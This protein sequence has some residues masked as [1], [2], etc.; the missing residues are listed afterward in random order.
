VTPAKAAAD[1]ILAVRLAI[2]PG[3]FLK[4]AKPADLPVF[5][6]SLFELIINLRPTFFGVGRSPLM[7]ASDRATDHD[8]LP[9]AARALVVHS[10]VPDVPGTAVRQ[11]DG[12]YAEAEGRT[13]RE[14]E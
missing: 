1:G 10:T 12:C 7:P 5:Q 8:R 3:R 14:A 11:N 13:Q 9:S 4:G 2:V 6:S